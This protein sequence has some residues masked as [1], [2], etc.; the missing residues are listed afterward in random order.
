[1]TARG[2]HPALFAGAMI[3]GVVAVAVL[4]LTNFG[5]WYNYYSYSGARVWYY[6][7]VDSPISL[8]GIAVVCI[9][10]FFAL[11]VSLKGAQNTD[12]VTVQ[13]VNRAFVASVVQ[14]I[15]I[16][17]AAVVFVAAVSGSDDWWF[18][19]GFYGSVIGVLMMMIFLR[20]AKQ[21]YTTSAPQG[22][23]QYGPPAQMYVQPGVQPYAPPAAYPAPQPQWQSVPPVGATP[24]QSPS[25]KFCMQCRQP[26]AE[27]V[28]FCERCG[29]PIQ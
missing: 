16:V 8:A 25:S 12:S 4:F 9:P 10:L 5:G 11:F 1:M 7:G 27:G 13:Q 6:I 22:F 2:W 19:T 24:G 23:P 29:R 3:G 18:C 21:Q 15:L 20:M 28:R 17:I 14:L 26:L